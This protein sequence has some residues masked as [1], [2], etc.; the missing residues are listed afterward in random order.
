MKNV[1]YTKFGTERILFAIFK[2][3]FHKNHYLIRANIKVVK[4]V[5]KQ[6]IQI[7]NKRNFF[8]KNQ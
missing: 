3:D 7:K 4:D 5:K 2:L 6:K 1:N 8:L